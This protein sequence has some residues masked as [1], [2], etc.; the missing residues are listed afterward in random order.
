MILKIKLVVPH[1][2]TAELRH[3]SFHI[4]F[5]LLVVPHAA[6][7]ELRLRMEYYLPQSFSV[8]PHAA[9]AELRR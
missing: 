4:Y 9:T 6:T 2:A 8:V 3:N 7:A 5:F 1:A